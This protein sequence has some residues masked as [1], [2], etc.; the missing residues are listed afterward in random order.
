MNCKDYQRLYKRFSD[1]PLPREVWDTPEYEQYLGHLHECRACGDWFMAQEAERMGVHPEEHVCVH[2]AYH[3]SQ[4]PSSTLDPQDDADVTL[5]YDV[6]NRTYGIPV[7]DG[8]SSHIEIKYCPWCGKHC[9]PA[10]P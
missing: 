6:S 9:V 1:L 3:I 2:L 4:E 10:D 7:R 8:G 5:T